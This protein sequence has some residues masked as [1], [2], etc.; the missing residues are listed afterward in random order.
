MP[1]GIRV[2]LEA[3]GRLDVIRRL[4]QPGTQRRSDAREGAIDA[5]PASWTIAGE[6][7]GFAQLRICVVER[8]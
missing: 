4:Q 8:G 1:G 2:D 3:L 7:D 6:E 5:V